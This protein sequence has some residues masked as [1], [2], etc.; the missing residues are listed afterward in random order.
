MC[1]NVA[2]FHQG[3]AFWFTDMGAADPYYVSPILTAATFLLV[4]ESGSVEGAQNNPNMN[5]MRWAMRAL[6][7][8]MVPMTASLP[9]G[10]F[11]YWTTTN[12]LSIGI[13]RTLRIQSVKKFLG[14]PHVAIPNAAASNA[15]N[16]LKTSLLGGI[17]SKE[18]VS[19]KLYTSNPTRP[20]THD[21]RI[22]KSNI[23][24]KKKKKKSVKKVN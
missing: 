24:S 13:T 20:Q 4:I 10:V 19:Q 9:Q 6:S 8:A 21:P 22:T 1:D 7:V 12:I 17:T 16:D 18:T 11:V 5:T 15:R 2:S 3:G 23:S 14:I